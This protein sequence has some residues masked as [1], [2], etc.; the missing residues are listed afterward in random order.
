MQCHDL[1]RGGATVVLLLVFA[2][3]L[4][5]IP[6]FQQKVFHIEQPSE[7]TEDQPI[8]NLVF[9]DCE[10]NDKLNFEVSNPDFKVEP[11]GSLV[12]LKNITE[13]GRALFIHA[14]SAQAEDMAEVLIVGGKDHHGS[15]KEIF[16][17]EDG[18]LGILRHKRAIVATPILIPENQR[19][20]FPRAVGRVSKQLPDNTTI[21]NRE[22]EVIDSDRTEGSKFRLSGKG[23]DQE[24]KGTFKINENT[25]EIS[26]TRSLDREATPTYQLQVEIT[27]VSGKSIEGPVLLEIIVIDQNDNRPIFR[28]GPYVGHVMEGSPTGS[29]VMRMMAFDADDPGT[30]N[31]L[32]RYNI[33][34]Q[35]PDKPSPNMFFIDPEKGDIVTVVSP[36][37]LDRETMENPKY[38]LIIEAKDMAGLDVGL[39]GTAT[40]TI[41][42]DDKNDHPPE[43]T[44]KEFQATVK[45]GVTR[46]IV[47]LSV[48]DRDD[49][50]TG[51]W[52]AVYTIINGNPGQS[53]EIHT[54]PKTNEGMLSV[55]KPL[56][57]EISAFH[58]LLIKVENEDPLV[59]DI[60][61]GPSSTATVQI[62]VL[63]VNEGPVF[64][65]DPMTV[66]KQENIPIGS[67]VLTVS[68][69]DPDTLQHQTI[70]YSVYKDPAGWLEINPTNGTIFTTAVL[71]R[72][73]LYVHNNVYTALFQAIDSGNPPATGTGTLQITLE[74]VND[75]APAIYP[76]LAKV[77]DDAKD[78]RVVVLGA[79]DKDLH[80]NT[81]PFKFELS[82]QSGPDKVWKITK[83]NNTHAQ[84]SLLQN[85]KKAN[86][87]IPILVTDSGKPPLTN[88]TELK[89]Q[90]CSC[91]KS[92]MD[93]SA[94][95]ALHI[96]MILI[97]LFSLFSLF[98][99]PW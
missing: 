98:S 39:T 26:V 85:L 92:K 36:A 75:N 77:C 2:E 84:V 72:E 7:F 13:A 82:K 48:E 78:L 80:P 22:I 99:L 55:V 89:V 6:G 44:K 59:P 73:S 58:T 41:V 53:F 42:I 9:D 27:D 68:A 8:L 16:K 61:Y 18:S 57:Y 54:N 74:D 5:C 49:P 50:A 12:A 86:Y 43:F 34:K 19:P 65:P 70:R 31:A 10:G 56:D 87:N 46:V 96:S 15:L 67:V 37:L 45:E 97:L 88:N 40:A 25:G 47:N 21:Q 3:D 71:D 32:L 90:V 38:E 63:D 30:D 11:N 35:T 94:A 28:E 93:C 95:D 69:T 14:R 62:T 17:I 60:A 4:E 76:T 23:V 91:K 24:P 52:R 20:P 51:A 64:H 1:M 83:I 66:T 33:L 81:D 29:T 79:S